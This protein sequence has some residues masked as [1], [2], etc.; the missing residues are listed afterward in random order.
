MRIDRLDLLTADLA[1]QREFYA[2]E[3][4][5]PVLEESDAV[6]SLQAG[7]SQ[8]I[9]GRAPE[10]WQGYYHF[11]FNI[12]ED[13]FWDA[14]EWLS[15]RVTLIKDNKGE[16]EFPSS[17]EWNAHSVYF[18]DPAGNILEF[19]ARHDLDEHLDRPFDSQNILSISEIGIV[20]ED[21]P[22]MVG[23]LQS[24]IGISPYGGPSSDTFTAVGDVHG[25]FIVVKR[26]RIWFPDTGKPAVP[27]SLGVEVTT[28]TGARYKLSGL[29]Y[30][31]DMYGVG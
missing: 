10:G 31:I 6:L 26:G 21:V 7:R 5:L 25:L 20:S 27:S 29:P 13:Q 15:R 22:S 9:F 12:P 23:S 1:V 4:P 2:N 28:G 18:Y 3:L 17:K 30:E 24:Q 8:L 16:D 19:I 11:A 14:K